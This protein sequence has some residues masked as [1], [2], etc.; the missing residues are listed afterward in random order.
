MFRKGTI[1]YPDLTAVHTVNQE[2][3]ANLIKERLG[4]NG[5]PAF[6]MDRE[7]SGSYLR[8]IGL[9]T[10]FGIDIYVNKEQADAARK[11]IDEFLSDEEKLTDEELE[12][13][14]LEAGTEC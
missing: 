7:D 14:A 11:L 12:E 1:P 4:Q 13:I 10:P 2:Y 6:Y 8:I 5:I 3:E 9:G